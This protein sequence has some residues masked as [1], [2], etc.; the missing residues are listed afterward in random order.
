MTVYDSNMRTL[1]KTDQK[2][3]TVG[4]VQG[5][6]KNADGSITLYIGPDAPEGKE[7]NWVKTIPGQ[8]WFSYFRLYSP[9][10]PFFD[11]SWVLPDFEK[12]KVE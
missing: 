7:K 5:F 6:D 11:G 1:I 9:T 12:A 2:K 10:E 4:S 8:N 3:P